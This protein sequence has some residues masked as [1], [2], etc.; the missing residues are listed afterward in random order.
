MCRLQ[1]GQD[2][3]PDFSSLTSPNA[4]ALAQISI[5]ELGLQYGGPYDSL[6]IIWNENEKDHFSSSSGENL[7][8]V[9]IK[10]QIFVSICLLQLII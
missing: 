8:Y 6:I 9:W 10:Q 5:L 2:K 3:L 1:V 7:P 4:D